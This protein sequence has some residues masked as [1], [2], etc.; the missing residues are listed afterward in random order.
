M[1]SINVSVDRGSSRNTQI[2]DLFINTLVVGELPIGL[3]NL[4]E[5]T[6][7]VVEPVQTG[8]AVLEPA[9]Q[10]TVKAV[11]F[12]LSKLN[13]RATVEIAQVTPTQS[14][15]NITI[16]SITSPA[17]VTVN[18]TNYTYSWLGTSVS[19]K[20][21]SLQQALMTANLT[22]YNANS[23][24]GVIGVLSNSGASFTVSGS[25]LT[26]GTANGNDTVTVSDYIKTLKRLTAL[27][28]GDLAVGFLI[29]PSGYSKLRASDC[30]LMTAAANELAAKHNL[31]LIA[32][33]ANPNLSKQDGV[34]LGS[35]YSVPS[36]HAVG[37]LFNYKGTVYSVSAALT[38]TTATNGTTY[39]INTLVFLPVK[40]AVYRSL[41]PSATFLDI[42]AP[43]EAELI[44]FVIESS[45]D[46]I[47]RWVNLGGLTIQDQGY[48]SE[49]AIKNYCRMVPKGLD[50]QCFIY[51]NYWG[52]GTSVEYPP[53]IVVAAY[54][55]STWL[56][57]GFLV[58][59]AG[60]RYPIGE[61]TSLS[62]TPK[63]SDLAL[64]K[65]YNF[66][67]SK[68]NFHIAGVRSNAEDDK[69]R[70]ITG[71][72]T[73]AM[74]RRQTL[75]AASAVQYQPLQGVGALLGTVQSTFI[76]VM[77]NL[78]GLFF[79]RQYRVIADLTNNTLDSL[80]SGI[81]NVKIC[82]KLAPD[83]DEVNLIVAVKALAEEL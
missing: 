46:L 15:T 77:E 44:N 13:N 79:N 81:V 6:R 68:G 45:E 66:L 35:S 74:V 26:V 20:T 47:Q 69:F 23:T 24:L 54:F 37:S 32:D 8:N 70:W 21:A 58:N 34:N 10:V 56:T 63:S 29:I 25:G 16:G 3:I 48:S 50:G 62:Y 30:H 65:N 7:R 22:V 12:L 78:A 31:V 64:A 61:I 9:Q 40:A 76:A 53:S 19:A 36:A 28:V 33:I 60:N 5:P 59:H 1:P 38:T 72:L 4:T 11:N 43:T 51:T 71:S 75:L 52:D 55:I 14:Y 57:S 67:S 82:V 17:I 2:S 39:P 49:A 41:S 80:Q 18:G 42:N 83:L 73:I 27:D